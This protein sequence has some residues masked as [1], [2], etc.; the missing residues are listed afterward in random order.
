V[1][2]IAMEEGRAGVRANCVAPGF[3]AG[4][5]GQGI[6]DAVG[7]EAAAQIVRNVPMRRLGQ[8]EEV[9]DAVAF[10]SSPQ[11]SYVTG[12]TLFV[13]GGMEL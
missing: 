2:G 3:I 7:P 13:S 1:R 6:I 4:G 5:L 12:N 8:V 10:L 9:A 11:A